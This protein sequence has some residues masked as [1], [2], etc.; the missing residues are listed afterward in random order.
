MTPYFH[1]YFHRLQCRRI[2]EVDSHKDRRDHIDPDRTMNRSREAQSSANG[3]KGPR[4]P[5]EIC[6]PLIFVLLAFF[7]AH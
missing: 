7:A 3:G 6:F 5:P 4:I 2:P 1:P